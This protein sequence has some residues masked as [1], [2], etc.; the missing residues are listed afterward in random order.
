VTTALSLSCFSILSLFCFVCV[1]C[2]KIV[3]LCLFLLIRF[4]LGY[5]H[6]TESSL[7][8][9][10]AEIAA[11]PPSGNPLPWM[12]QE[13][14]PPRCTEAQ[15]S[16]LCLA[17]GDLP[18]PAK[19][20]ECQIPHW[21]DKTKLLFWEL[22]QET[23]F[24][25]VHRGPALLTIPAC[26]RVLFSLSKSWNLSSSME[27]YLASLC[28]PRCLPPTEAQHSPRSPKTRESPLPC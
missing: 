17:V 5:I 12:S 7:T 11:S 4:F 23:C 9:P 24:P 10:R 3:F 6:Y 25:K 28:A 15:H 16:S 19:K 8:C 13:A 1:F 21:G 26:R 27:W 14:C 2:K 18:L 20:L 22:N